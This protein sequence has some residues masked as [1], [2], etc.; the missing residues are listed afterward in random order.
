ME[1][2]IADNKRFSIAV[3]NCLY[4]GMSFVLTIFYIL[5]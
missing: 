2:G 5:N 1:S 4:Q 3:L